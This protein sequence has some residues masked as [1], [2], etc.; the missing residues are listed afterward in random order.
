MF[1]Q[2]ELSFEY[3]QSLRVINKLTPAMINEVNDI[4]ENVIQVTQNKTIMDN[5]KSTL[6]D[7]NNI[8]EQVMILFKDD[9]IDKQLVIE[10]VTSLVG[11]ILDMMRDIVKVVEFLER[12]PLANDHKLHIK[13]QLGY[14][15]SLLKEIV[16]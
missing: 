16:Y 2:A 13:Y 11:L 8:L 3:S 15:R 9:N 4:I 14:L 7:I 12:F 6:S 1:K 5:I 10:M